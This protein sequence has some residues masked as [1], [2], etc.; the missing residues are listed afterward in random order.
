MTM[1]RYDFI[2]IDSERLSLELSV[3]VL[4]SH[5]A[6]YEK[7]VILALCCTVSPKEKRAV[8]IYRSV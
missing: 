7:P 2:D 8:G 1:C 6:G 5:R 3:A 4:R